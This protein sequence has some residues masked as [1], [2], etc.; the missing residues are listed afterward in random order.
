MAEK[1]RTARE[2]S[3]YVGIEISPQWLGAYRRKLRCNAGPPFRFELSYPP[4]V[5]T[6]EEEAE[7][8]AQAEHDD[9]M[10]LYGI[11]DDDNKGCTVLDAQNLEDA[12]SAAERLWL[13]EPHDGA[14]GY[15]IFSRDW[16]C[17]HAFRVCLDNV[18]MLGDVRAR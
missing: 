6:P 16:S 15:A 17:K 11:P 18:I 14:I 3:E 12:K 7:E 5:L 2:V 4:P 13:T 8:L 9:E 10:G 1:K